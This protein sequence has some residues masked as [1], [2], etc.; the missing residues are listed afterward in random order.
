VLALTT[1]AF[2]EAPALL[3]LDQPLDA[4]PLLLGRWWLHSL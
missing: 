2:G 4:L 1:A 3:L